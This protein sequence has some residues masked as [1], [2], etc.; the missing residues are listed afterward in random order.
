MR[1]GWGISQRTFGCS[2]Q[3]NPGKWLWRWWKTNQP[4][5]LTQN[6]LCDCKEMVSYLKKTLKIMFTFKYCFF[7]EEKHQQLWLPGR[8]GSY[9]LVWDSVRWELK[10]KGCFC[11]W[12]S[13]NTSDALGQVIET[14]TCD[15]RILEKWQ[16]VFSPH[17]T[18]EMQLSWGLN[19]WWD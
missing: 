14:Q 12:D 3:W 17:F 10:C 6:S 13:A 18:H 19:P 5:L 2:L 15:W 4:S 1:P 16:N 8:G 9:F 7:S 11:L